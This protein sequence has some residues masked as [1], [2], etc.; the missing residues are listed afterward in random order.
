MKKPIEVDLIRICEHKEHGTFGVMVYQ[1]APICPTVELPWKD[2]K[3]NVSCIPPNRYLVTPFTRSNGGDAYL[4]NDVPGRSSILIHVANMAK[5]L[6]GCI[7][8]GTGFGSLW[9]KNTQGIGVLHSG[10]AMQELKKL[11]DGY[12]RWYL[13]ITD[14]RL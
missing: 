9:I 10:A 12:E 6:K 7:A 8:P 13:T 14:R 3:R 11:V 5:E 4:L 2:N 1:N